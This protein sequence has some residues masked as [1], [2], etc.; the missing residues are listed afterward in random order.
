MRHRHCEFRGREGGRQSGV[1]HGG[2]DCGATSAATAASSRATAGKRVAGYSAPHGR[3]EFL[4]GISFNSAAGVVAPHGN[5]DRPPYPGNPHT[6]CAVPQGQAAGIAQLERPAARSLQCGR[7]GTGASGN[8]AALARGRGDDFRRHR[9]P[10]KNAGGDRGGIG[11][12]AGARFGLAERGIFR[13]SERKS[14][15]RSERRPERGRRMT[16]QGHRSERIA[17]EIR[18][19]VSLMLA[20]ELKDPRLAAPVMVTEVRMGAGM[21][22]VRVFVSLAGDEAERAT[23]LEGLQAAK[24]YVRHELVER[25]HMRRAPEVLFI[26]DETEE[27]NNRIENLLRKA[28]NPEEHSS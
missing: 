1:L 4:D 18:N 28:K 17:E 2:E 12:L 15:R 8:L 23:T 16:I 9:V 11:T 3:R 26:L 22:T 6:G 27:Y 7:G 25:L 24:G 20:G 14:E 21:R 10:G 19:E 5:A 13:G